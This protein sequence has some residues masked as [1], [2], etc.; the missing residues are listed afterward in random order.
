MHGTL[1]F[2]VILLIM[3]LTLVVVSLSNNA[4]AQTLHNRTLYEAGK[5]TSGLYDNVKIDV[6]DKPQDIGVYEG[7]GTVYV[8]NSGS[9]TVSVISEDKNNT[10]K[11]AQDIPVGNGPI[12]IG[13]DYVTDTVYVANEG[14]LANRGYLANSLSGTV[15]VIDNTA[16]RVVAGVTFQVNPF[17]SGSS[18]CD[19]LT[20]PDPSDQTP[21]TP[22]GKYTYVY[23]GD[24]CTARP[25]NGFEFQ[26]WE[27]NLKGKATQ[28]INVSRLASPWDALPF[29]FSSQL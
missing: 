28:P 5:Q 15:Y 18:V 21:P 12:A 22:I 7:R 19:D 27:E 17:N 24:Q 11:I 6:G 1:A 4:F 23:S 8:A 3:V 29:R 2:L 26:S 20:T 14:Y 10:T 13:V 25:N 16:G 9:N